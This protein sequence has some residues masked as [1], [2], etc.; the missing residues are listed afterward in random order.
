MRVFAAQWREPRWAI[1]DLRMPRRP[2][3][4][5][6]GQLGASFRRQVPVAG[7]FVTDFCAPSIQLIVEVDGAIH[8]RKVGPNARRDRKL[9]RAGSLIVRVS[10]ELV[11]IDLQAALALIHAA[12]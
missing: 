4:R 8:A 5:N 1:R 12:L 2:K 3:G 10:A 6:G 11:L 7:L 9:H